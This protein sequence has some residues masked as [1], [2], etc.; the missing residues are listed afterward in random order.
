LIVWGQIIGKDNLYVVS[1]S[2]IGGTCPPHPLPGMAVHD[3]SAD[4]SDQPTRCAHIHVDL[5]TYLLIKPTGGC[6]LLGPA[7]DKVLTSICSRTTSRVRACGWHPIVL[8][9]GRA[10]DRMHGVNCSGQPS[11][12]VPFLCLNYDP[13]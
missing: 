5:L 11:F 9:A 13:L 12:A 1:L 2:N 8:M 3:D 7:A 6:L 10:A 4:F